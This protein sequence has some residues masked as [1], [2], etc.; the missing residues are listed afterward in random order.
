MEKK[1]AGRP[2]VAAESVWSGCRV[3]PF[4]DVTTLIDLPKKIGM[5]SFILR[6]HVYVAKGPIDIMVKQPQIT[7]CSKTN[8]NNNYQ[9]FFNYFGDMHWTLNEPGKLSVNINRGLEWA[10]SRVSP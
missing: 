10:P 5:S 4:N 2:C 9:L 6:A 3:I 1:V 8:Q 7:S